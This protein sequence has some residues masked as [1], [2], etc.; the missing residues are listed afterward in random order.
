MNLMEILNLQE[1][2][3]DEFDPLSYDESA[4]TD[5]LSRIEELSKEQR[6]LMDQLDAKQ[7]SVQRLSIKAL[8]ILR[9]LLDTNCYPVMSVSI[10]SPSDAAD[11]PKTEAVQKD[12][13]VQQ[14]STLASSA[15]DQEID[16]LP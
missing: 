1:A 8:R 14:E 10:L 6:A 3:D 15:S 11:Y 9:A 7:A 5:L 2:E 12:L 13:D 4:L 16:P